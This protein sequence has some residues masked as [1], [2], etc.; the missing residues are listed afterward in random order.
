M[1]CPHCHGTGYLCD[2]CKCPMD[3]CQCPDEDYWDEDEDELPSGFGTLAHFEN[4]ED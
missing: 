4:E 1:E 2:D 3:Y